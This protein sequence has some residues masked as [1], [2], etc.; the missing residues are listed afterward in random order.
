MMRRGSVAVELALLL[1]VLLV[2]LVGALEWGRVLEAQV[3]IIQV[4]RDGALA[5]ARAGPDGDPVGVA[6]ARARAALVAVGRDA[7][8]SEVG[9]LPV[10]LSVG[11]AVTVTVTTPYSG[12][13]T[14]VPVPSQLSATVTARLEG[15]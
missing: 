9:V 15:G 6:E 4:A 1:P 7:G 13:S 11:E 2:L 3:T 14:L 5:G 12:G 10:S 8:A